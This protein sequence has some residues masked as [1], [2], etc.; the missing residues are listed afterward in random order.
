MS[1]T[2]K[3]LYFFLAIIF[4]TIFDCYFS[5]QLMQNG[6]RLS[7]NPILS[8]VFVKNEGAAFNILQGSK[9]FLITFSA[10]AISAIILAIIKKIR[11][12]STIGLFFSA[13]LT[14]GILVNMLERIIFGHVRDFIKLNFIDFPI[15]NISDI[16]INISVFVIVIIIIK[17]NYFKNNET[18]N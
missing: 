18:K 1:K 11:N 7:E 13:M 4:F 17:N 14:S 9:I 16:F 6:F 3:T 10:T 15:F 8:I 5:E 2:S 12:I